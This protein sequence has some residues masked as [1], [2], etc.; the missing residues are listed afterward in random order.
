M[1]DEQ[2]RN[3][4]TMYNMENEHLDREHLLPHL[5]HPPSYS[6]VIATVTNRPPPSYV[7]FTDIN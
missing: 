1:A 3:G 7:R 6:D 5:P 4:V 2:R